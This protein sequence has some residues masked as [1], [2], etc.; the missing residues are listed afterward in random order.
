M[1]RDGRG[2]SLMEL[3]VVVVIVTILAA[4]A[5]PLLRNYGREKQRDKAKEAVTGVVAAQQIYFQQ[6]SSRSYAPNLPELQGSVRSLDLSVAERDWA[7]AT[8][9][10]E[11]GFTVTATGLTK[12]P[13]RGM[14]VMY[15]YDRASGGSWAP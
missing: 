5:V 15:L 4:V 8:N 13:T 12:R 1:R 3:M 14:E 11:M 2:F 7:I 6:H 9:G 10:S